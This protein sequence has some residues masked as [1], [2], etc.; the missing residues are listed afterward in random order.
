MAGSKRYRLATSG[1]EQFLKKEADMDWLQTTLVILVLAGVG[2]F[3][4]CN[5]SPSA[6]DI[7]MV[8]P[9]TTG[10]VT[11]QTGVLSIGDPSYNR[12]NGALGV[13]F[14]TSQGLYYDTFVT[15]EELPPRG[16]FQLL[17]NGKTE[18]GP[19]DPGY[20]GGRWKVPNDSGGYD[21][22]LCPLLPPGREAP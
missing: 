3:A 16:P 20:R 7:D 21:Y 6:P 15:A 14:V 4:G 8:T 12:G 22:F 5:A 19:G 2:L 17:E 1:W 18:F 13:V 9:V 11:D 10:A